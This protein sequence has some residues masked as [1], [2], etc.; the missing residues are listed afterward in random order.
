MSFLSH[1]LTIMD[2]IKELLEPN[3]YQTATWMALGA[4]LLLLSQSYL[5]Y[6]LG[7]SVPLLYLGYRLMKMIYQT[8][9][10]PSVSF[11]SVVRG[12]WT[13]TL[14]EPDVSKDFNG[15]SDGLVLFVLG[16]RINQSVT[17]LI[18]SFLDLAHGR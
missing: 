12:R 1:I 17:S 9:R 7:N 18:M 6:N 4:S 5:P 2:T 16:A 11:G 15:G 13:A 3:D 14:G 10:L 8:I